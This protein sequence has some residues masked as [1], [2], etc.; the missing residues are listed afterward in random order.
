[1]INETF[2]LRNTFAENFNPS[3]IGNPGPAKLFGTR[4]VI[5]LTGD[6]D[7]E[8]G[9]M[10]INQ[11]GKKFGIYGTDLG[12]SFL[13]DGKLYFLFGDTTRRGPDDGLPQSAMPA[14]PYNEDET[15]YD[16][17]AY[18]TSDR[19]YDGIN[20]IFNSDFPRVDDISQL[21]AEHPI[22]GVSIGNDMYVFFTTD[23]M[24]E[25]RIL[26]RRTVLARS[27]DGGYNFGNSLY[28]FSK[29]KFIHVSIQIINNENIQG[30]PD[31]MGKG[32]LIWGSGLYRKSD[33]YLAYMPLDEI[34]N[35]SSLRFFAGFD[36]GSSM[37]I[38]E[39]N[40]SMAKPLFSAGCIG[41]LSIRWNYYLEK[42][43]MLYNCNLCN[44]RG[45]II[46]LADKPWGPWSTPKI[47][48]DPADGYGRFIHQPGH[49]SLY[50]RDRD[51]D[52]PS[53][54]GYEYG[55]YQMTPYAT[56]IK[57]R[58]TKIY[59]TLSTW[60]PYQ[61]IQM[62]AIITGEEEEKN[63]RPYADNMNDRNDRK[64]AYVSVLLA[65]LAKIKN[66]SL[67]NSIQNSTYIGDHIEWAQFHSHLK[68]RSE[69]KT[70]FLQLITNL[71]SD[72]DKADAYTAM[73]AAIVKLGYDYRSFNNSVNDSVYVKWALNAVHS[74][75]KEWLIDE[76]NEKID[77]EHFLQN[78]DYLCCAYDSDDSNE[79]KYARVSLLEAKLADNV[80]M[81]W[82][83]PFQGLLDCNSHIT[84]ARFRSVEEMREDL[85]YKFN[86]II[87][88]FTS[89]NQIAKVYEE[90]TKVILELTDNVSDFREYSSH[91]EWALSMINNNKQEIIISEISKLINNERFLTS[92]P[93]NG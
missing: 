35:R 71:V 52:L 84:W 9:Q 54:L 40:E 73:T 68:L 75:H 88:K 17:I 6:V 22:E 79:F 85:A 29:D 19:A 16:S 12:V 24:E 82:D 69:L 86:Q 21:T 38:W 78:N 14:A 41:E 83:L 4:K 27:I 1:V 58:Y 26:P 90:I 63:P 74:G 32:L 42:W 3:C 76:I 61:V 30:L 55:P 10:T 25:G 31:P 72:R 80:G 34:T 92:V 62:S 48:F 70:K 89:P 39:S 8:T 51:R 50:D 5:Q 7:R 43:I 91:Y 18:T 36:P 53:D 11:T 64:Y 13:H 93:T 37:P 47:V 45:V 33:A 46:R 87:Y 60:N 67:G 77:H 23:L 49:D 59:F 57:G 66:I 28:T 15:D 44:T 56:G 20:L 65:H 81:K 2:D